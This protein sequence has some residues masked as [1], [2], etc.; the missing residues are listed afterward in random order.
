MFPEPLDRFLRMLEWTDIISVGLLAVVGTDKALAVSLASLR[1]LMGS[2]TGVGGGACSVMYFWRLVFSSEAP[3][4]FCGLPAPPH[5]GQF[6][7]RRG[8]KPAAVVC[9]ALLPGLEALSYNVLSPADVDLT[10]H[11][12]RSVTVLSQSPAW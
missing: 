10:P 12:M 3:Y 11:V 2:I 8:S 7:S 5:I 6:V 4:A 9:V 1:L